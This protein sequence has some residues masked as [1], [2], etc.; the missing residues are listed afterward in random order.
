MQHQPYNH[1]WEEL[2]ILGRRLSLEIHCPV[3]YPGYD[4]NGFTCKHDI[5]FPLYVLKG[6]DWAWARREHESGKGK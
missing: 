4:K 5:F 2:D 3:T 1:I 6:G